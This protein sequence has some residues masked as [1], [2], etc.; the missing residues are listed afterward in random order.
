MEI[1]QIASGAVF[2]ATALGALLAYFKYKPGQ[3]E[4]LDLTIAQATMKVTHGSFQLVTTEL[5]EQFKRMSAEMVEIRAEHRA[6][7]DATDLQISEL[8][9]EVRSE[10][11]E[12]DTLKRENE[13]LNE[14]VLLLE[15]EVA[16]LKS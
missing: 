14:R 11:S 8:G 9:D 10:R 1:S 5:E 15:E 4:S 2:L 12:K 16:R 3:K 7:R 13:R 6:Y